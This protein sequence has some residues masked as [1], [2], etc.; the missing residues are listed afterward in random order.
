MIHV[1]F[2]QSSLWAPGPDV[3][4]LLS[5]LDAWYTPN[6]RMMQAQFTIPTHLLL[7]LLPL[8][9]HLSW[10]GTI[11]TNY[12]SEKVGTTHGSFSFIPLFPISH[13]QLYFLNISWVPNS[14]TVPRLTLE[15][16]I[17]CIISS[18]YHHGPDLQACCC[19]IPSLTIVRVAA[20]D[21]NTLPKTCWRHACPWSGIQSWPSRLYRGVPSQ[22]L[23]LALL[24]FQH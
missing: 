9:F 19:L 20:F 4:V 1:S 18:S 2:N 7:S 21:H 14:I 12:P 3:Q 17:L 11:L 6:S 5:S 13:H 22:P 24:F 8:Q 23:I 10:T 15:S 16:C